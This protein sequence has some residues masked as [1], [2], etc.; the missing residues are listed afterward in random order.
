MSYRDPKIID[1]KS[2]LIIPNAI[3]NMGAQISQGW[4]A[5]LAATRK[6]N[7]IEKQRLINGGIK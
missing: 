1:D 4:S 2:G 6:E 5:S 7:D 3:A